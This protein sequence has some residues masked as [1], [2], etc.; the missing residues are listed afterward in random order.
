MGERFALAVLSLA[1]LATASPAAGQTTV[2]VATWNI[3][4]VGSPGSVEYDAALEILAR[5]DADVVALNEIASAADA[6]HFASLASDAGYPHHA[7]TSGAP[8]GSDRNALLSRHPFASPAVEHSAADLSGDPAANDITRR[9]LEA[10]IDVPGSA[11]NLT[12]VSTHWK[13]GTGNDDEFRRVVESHRV[14]QAIADLDG[15]LDAFVVVGDVNEEAD[16]TP[17]TP[18]PF[19]GLPSGLPGSFS[20]GA[21]LTSMLTAGHLSNDPFDPIEA[22][23][24]VAAQLAPALQVDGSDS[25]RPASGRRLDYVFVSGAL[26][27]GG[28]DAEVFD[29]T[30]EGLSGGLAKSGSALAASTSLDASDHLLVFVDLTIPAEAAAIPGL[31]GPGLA[32]LA[33]ALVGAAAA[34]LGSQ[35]R[36]HSIAPS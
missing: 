28:V 27:E 4:T 7:S 21:D 10:V 31:A 19:T 29:S 24:G 16:S 2:R 6:L 25:T 14:A 35:R 18:N 23:P 8:F 33:A 15:A 13:S 9:I 17:R 26:W 32:L 36:R 34:A 1:A 20:L 22:D 30:D 3:E 5:V 11:G 12:V